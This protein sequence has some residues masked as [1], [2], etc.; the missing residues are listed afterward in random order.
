MTGRAERQLPATAASGWLRKDRP[1]GEGAA[2][3]KVAGGV[4]RAAAVADADLAQVLDV[5]HLSAR[6]QAEL[7]SA[8]GR[9]DTHASMCSDCMYIVQT[10]CMS[11]V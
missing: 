10:A 4:V 11:V 7:L 5:V 2:A 6:Q 1:A 8:S 3:C 9:S